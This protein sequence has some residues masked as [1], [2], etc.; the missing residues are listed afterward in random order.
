MEI[1]P[2]L[3]RR[4]K[5][6]RLGGLLPALPDRATQARQAKLAPLEFLEL[7]L[8]DEIDRRDSQGLVRRLEAAG[9][10]ELVTYEQLVWETAVSYDRA[11]VRELFGLHWLG[12]QENVIF[13]GPVGVGKSWLARALGHSACRA[14]HHV[15]LQQGRQAAP[16]PASVARRQLL[17]A[18][19]A[20][21]ARPGP[22]HPRRLRPA[23]AHRPAVERHLR[24]PRRARSAR[25][26]DPHEQPGRGRMGRPLRR[27]HPRQQCTRSLR[28]P[29]PSDHHGGAEPA[30]RPGPQP[31]QGRAPPLENHAAGGI[32]R[33]GSTGERGA[34]RLYGPRSCA[35]ALPK[36]RSAPKGLARS[37]Q[38]AVSRERLPALRVGESF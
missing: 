35:R 37:A 13:C 36:R 21:L 3:V 4:L 38:D 25:R 34:T 7:L 6:L 12:A 18:R 8:Q 26:D 1:A 23:Q 9:F 30:R 27:P 29:R 16:C 15:R 2:D 28:A 31:G 10:E 32:A 5:R 20:H 33:Y 19:T 17:R 14:G 24:R 22:A 11:R